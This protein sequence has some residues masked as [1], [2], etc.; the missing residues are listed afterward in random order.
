MHLTS[1]SL[2]SVKLDAFSF[3]VVNYQTQT[4]HSRKFPIVTRYLPFSLR[5]SACIPL[6]WKDNF[7]Y[8]SNYRLNM[9]ILARPTSA[10]S[11][12]LLSAEIWESCSDELSANPFCFLVEL[13]A[14]T[15]MSLFMSLV[16]CMLVSF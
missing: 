14:E 5:Q 6:V 9:K 16:N 8:T 7:F 15:A 3:P 12:S 4:V 11:A 2:S 1:F 10:V 13:Y